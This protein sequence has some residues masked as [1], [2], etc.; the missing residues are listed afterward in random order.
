ML[1]DNGLTPTGVDRPVSPVGSAANDL[2][3]AVGDLEE[4]AAKLYERL[5]PVLSGAVQS[6]AERTIG[7]AEPLGTSLLASGYREASCRV[8]NVSARL[9]HMLETLEV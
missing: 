3:I 1:P 5:S 9:L 8:R 6:D 4:I 7:R 2:H